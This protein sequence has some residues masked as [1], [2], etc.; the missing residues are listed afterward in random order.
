MPVRAGSKEL[1]KL[2]RQLAPGLRLE[3]D[4]KAKLRIVQENGEPL[5][6][7]DGRPVGLPNSPAPRTVDDVAVR[8]RKVGALRESKGKKK[9]K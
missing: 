9:R 2:A 1:R 6:Y 5:R 8:L 4:G 7:E 3:P